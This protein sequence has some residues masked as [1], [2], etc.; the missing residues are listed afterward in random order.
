MSFSKKILYTALAALLILT[1]G[2]PVFA[3]GSSEG[4]AIKIGAVS[5]RTGDNAGLGEMQGNGAKLA[6]AE[7][8]AK[9]GVLG[10]QIELILEDSQGI[11][12][13]AVAALNK[14]LHRDNV[15][16]VIG[17]SQSSPCFAML[18]VIEKAQVPMLPHGT[19]VGICEQGNQWIF[20]TRANDEVKFGSLGSYLIDDVGFKRLA[21]LHDSADYGIGGAASI[22]KALA[23]RTNI[24]V[25]NETFTPGDKDF[26]SQLL[27]I[28]NANPDVLVLIGPMVD[29]GL[30]MKQARQMGIEARF[31]GGAGIESTTTVGAA[32]GAAENLIFAAGFISANPD[33]QVSD[34]VTSFEKNYGKTPDDFAATGYD[35]IYLA[36]AAIEKAGS[37]DHAAIQKALRELTFKGVEGTF[38]FDAN[39]EGLHSM[40]FGTIKNGATAFFDPS[41]K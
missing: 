11:P 3:G 8:N 5:A 33:P 18:P 7:I 39:G 36:A 32:G 30:A 19:N 6:V 27:K 10:R 2:T 17:D 28:R 15:A 1:A 12:A 29:M 22:E 14:L 40:Q 34:F 37:T 9:G 41:M 23:G 25:A 38:D 24:I 20:R 26:S 4:G 16:V 21:I 35:S 13:Q 31:A